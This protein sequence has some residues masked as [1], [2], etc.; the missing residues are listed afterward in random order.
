MKTTPT[1][2]KQNNVQSPSYEPV[3]HCPCNKV[4][5][6]S[7]RIDRQHLANIIVFT[8][9]QAMEQNRDVN[10]DCQVFHDL[11]PTFQID[12]SSAATA[13][14]LWS[15]R[16]RRSV[17]TTLLHFFPFGIA[18]YFAQVFDAHGV[19]S[20]WCMSVYYSYFPVVVYA[21]FYERFRYIYT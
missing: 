12:F 9:E 19:L 13:W 2:R 8:S 21:Y 11:A 16:R 7:G 3:V 14:K 1:V 17:V 20:G 5:D 4:E 15:F 6:R 10:P 18:H